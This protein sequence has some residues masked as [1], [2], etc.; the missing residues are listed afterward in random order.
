VTGAG[1]VI[2]VKRAFMYVV[3]VVAVAAILVAKSSKNHAPK[4]PSA[5]PGAHAS[6]SP[7]KT[8]EAAAADHKPVWLLI[9]STMC[10]PCKEMEQSAS[11]LRPEFD[12]KVVF[13][14]VIIDDPKAEPVL[15]RYKIELIPT[16]FFIDSSGRVR[17]KKVGAVLTSEL[18]KKLRKLAEVDG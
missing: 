3:I 5:K 12:G 10:I 4:S 13:V 1:E 2:R 17:E 16:S 7:M 14:G 8:I 18:R 11:K 15:K 9:H 6:D